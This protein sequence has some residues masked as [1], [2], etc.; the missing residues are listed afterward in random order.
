MDTKGKRN[1]ILKVSLLEFDW[2]SVGKCL[3][4]DQSIIDDIDR[5]E[6]N[7]QNKREKMLLKWLHQEGSRATYSCLM[8]VLEVLKLKD[9]AEAVTR[10]VMEEGKSYQSKRKLYC[11]M[12]CYDIQR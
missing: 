10:L 8:E 11:R 4:D 5:E 7:E 12:Q 6:H 1:I 9:T 3:L 2:K